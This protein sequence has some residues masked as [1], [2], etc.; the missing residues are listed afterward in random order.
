LDAIENRRVGDSIEQGLRV[1]FA[2]Q[3]ARNLPGFSP[4]EFGGR[5]ITLGMQNATDIVIDDAA[6]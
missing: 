1:V 4:R 3:S 6:G 2:K 5:E